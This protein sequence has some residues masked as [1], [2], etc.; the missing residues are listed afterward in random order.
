MTHDLLCPVTPADSIAPDKCW[1]CR[2]IERGRADEREAVADAIR[3]RILEYAAGLDGKASRSV[4][5]TCAGLATTAGL[6]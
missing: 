1:R 2:L 3:D 6:R 5:L 4:A